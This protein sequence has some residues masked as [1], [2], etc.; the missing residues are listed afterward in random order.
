[1]H[2]THRMP[3]DQVLDDQCDCKLTIEIQ[4]P[5]DHTKWIP[6]LNVKI[7]NLLFYNLFSRDG[8]NAMKKT[9]IKT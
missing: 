5:S 4:A 9:G 6:N 7:R 2:A 3:H 8:I 1:M